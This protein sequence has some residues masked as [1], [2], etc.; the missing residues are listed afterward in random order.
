MTDKT[1]PADVY[2]RFLNLVEAVRGLP[3]LP[4]LDPLEERILA[5]VAR[6]AQQPSRL[7]VRDVMAM[8][9]L[10]SPATIHGRL[11]SMREKGWIRLADTEDARRKQIALT[12]AALKHFDK[13]S[14][15]LMQ[16]ANAE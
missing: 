12:P 10:G 5:L 14:M 4:T 2:L 6:K 15:C 13:L 9:A 1:R 7:S 3:A 8:E 11:K 16:A